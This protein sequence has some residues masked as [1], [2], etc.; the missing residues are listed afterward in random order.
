MSIS[1]S[2][3]LLTSL[4]PFLQVHWRGYH[5]SGNIK[6]MD[7]GSVDLSLYRW[8]LGQS[9]RTRVARGHYVKALFNL[10][11]YFISNHSSTDNCGNYFHSY[12]F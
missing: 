9:S 2:S 11:H 12:V 3:S 6:V 7:Y 4:G 8:L 5:F 10:F 1:L